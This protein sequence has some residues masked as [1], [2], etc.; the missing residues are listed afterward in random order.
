M[1]KLTLLLTIF[2]S[3]ATFAGQKIPAW[4]KPLNPFKFKKSMLVEPDVISY[5]IEEAFVSGQRKLHAYMQWNGNITQTWLWEF[6]QFGYWYSANDWVMK[7]FRCYAYSGSYAQWYFPLQPQDD[8][9]WGW[10]LDAY[11]APL[12]P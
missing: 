11:M 4:D 2:I 5:G 1:K 12:Q 6:D 8:P 7:N 9:Y 10:Y 3:V